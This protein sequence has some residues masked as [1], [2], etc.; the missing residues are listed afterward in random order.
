LAEVDD[1]KRD[2]IE[3]MVKEN[4]YLFF[5]KAMDEDFDSKKLNWNEQEKLNVFKGVV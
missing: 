2:Q 3:E 4:C 1:R 5:K